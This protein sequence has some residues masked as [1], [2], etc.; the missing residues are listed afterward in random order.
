AA[1]SLLLGLL[2]VARLEPGHAAAGVHDLLLARVER[3]A[4]AADVGADLAG[5]LGAARGEGVTAG[6]GDLGDDVLGVDTGLHDAP[7]CD[8]RWVALRKR[9]RVNQRASQSFCH[10]V[11][12]S[13]DTAGCEMGRSDR[14]ADVLVLGETARRRL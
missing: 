10:R 11:A 13:G 1:G 14:L 2:A 4:G 9:R 6:A 8:C 3:V 7:W 12:R 5:R